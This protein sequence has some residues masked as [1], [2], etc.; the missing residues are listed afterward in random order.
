MTSS[1][2]ELR[3]FVRDDDVDSLTPELEAVSGLFVEAGIPVSYQVVPARLS[4]DAAEH[5]LALR[6]R[7]PDLVHLGQHGYSHEASVPGVHEWAEF[8][9]GRSADDQRRAIATG[10]R[11]LLEAFGDAFDG[12]VFTPPCHKYDRTT[13]Q[14]LESLGFDTV[15]ASY[16]IGIPARLFYLAGHALRRTRLLGRNVSYHGRHHPGSQVREVSVSVD[17]DLGADGERVSKTTDALVAE[18]SAAALRTE[19]VGIMLHHAAYKE[20]AKLD[21]LAALVEALRAGGARFEP[22]LT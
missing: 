5:M 4:A 14:T 6:R 9:G 2:R 8:A 18:V 21:T 22:L 11:Q 20:P 3:V 7:H 12:R 10:R 1:D 17:I 13:V 16:R 19:R 15:S